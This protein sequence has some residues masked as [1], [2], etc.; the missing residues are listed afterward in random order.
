MR[1]PHNYL[2]GV[3]NG[4]HAGVRAQ[5]TGFTGLYARQNPFAT[6]FEVV[7]VITYHRLFQPQV[8]Q[9]L[10]CHAGVLCRNEICAGKRRRRSGRHI[11]QIADGRCHQ[12]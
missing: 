4:G 6:L 10:Q 11:I 7:L 2:A 12:I 9:Q 8:V 5:G 3:G 1:I